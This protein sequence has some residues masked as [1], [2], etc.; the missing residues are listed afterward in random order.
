MVKSY[1]LQGSPRCVCDETVINP[2]NLLENFPTANDSYDNNVTVTSN[3][4]QITE[5]TLYVSIC[6]VALVAQ[7]FMDF[8]TS[9]LT[10]LLD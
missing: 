10:G 3:P 9:S 8:I 2:Y 6:D 7:Q 1:F 4:V 5:N